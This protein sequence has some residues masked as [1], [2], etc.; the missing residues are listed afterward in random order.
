MFEGMFIGE[1]G[2]I[3]RGGLMIMIKISKRGNLK[4]NI[5]VQDNWSKSIR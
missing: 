4:S 2:I 3:E 1:G 5:N